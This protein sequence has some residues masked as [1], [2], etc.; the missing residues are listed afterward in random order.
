[1]PHPARRRVRLIAASALLS[2]L[3]LIA[4]VVWLTRE[5]PR[6]Y[7]AIED[8]WTR[9]H[10]AGTTTPRATTTTTTTTAPTTTTTTTTTTRP[11]PITTT[12]PRTTTTTTTTWKPKPPTQAPSAD[13]DETAVLA[14][15]ND[16]RAKAGC[17]PVKWNDDLATAAR[18][19]SVDMATRD[20]F[21]HTS[22]DGRSPFER[23]EAQGYDSPGGEN[24]AAGQRTPESVMESWMNS[25]GHR[26]NI[27]NC[28]FTTLGVGI[29]EGGDY[30][31]YWTQNFGF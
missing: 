24:I 25:P 27:L 6:P 19:H 7:D 17:N 11:K 13:T 18:L 4:L 9:S 22:L 15:V 21:D 20:Y 5:E 10:L 30:G 3:A 28:D 26:A 2:T 29:G 1:M 14:I 31:I 8:N 23:M 12:P 16:E